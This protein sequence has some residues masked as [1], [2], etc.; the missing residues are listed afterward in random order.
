V[1]LDLPDDG[2]ADRLRTDTVTEE[3]DYGAFELVGHR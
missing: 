1:G 2:V 3:P